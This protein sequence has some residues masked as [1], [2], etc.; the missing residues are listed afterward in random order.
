M[1]EKL[2]EFEE[3]AKKQGG[4]VEQEMN[5]YFKKIDAYWNDVNK[6]VTMVLEELP[7]VYPKVYEIMSNL[8]LTPKEIYEKI[9]ELKMDKMTSHSMHAVVMAVIHCGGG[10][11]P[12]AA[13]ANMILEEIASSKIRKHFSESNYVS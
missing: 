13:N 1:N 5:D 8:D 2:K 10:E 3:W 7:K 6:N 12:Y 9:R 4:S 11:S